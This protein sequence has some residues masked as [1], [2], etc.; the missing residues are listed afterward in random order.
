MP[1]TST[2]FLEAFGR[3]LTGGGP[4]KEEDLYSVFRARSELMGWDVLPQP[5]PAHQ[6]G[7]WSM[8]E[9][10]LGAGSDAPRIG[11]AQVGLDAGV[12]LVMAMP[13][14][15]DNLDNSLRYFGA[16]ELSGYQVTATHLEPHQADHTGWLVS[17]LNWFGPPSRSAGIM[18][19]GVGD[20]GPDLLA[21]LRWQNTGLF[22][23]DATE[24]LTGWGAPPEMMGL[25]IAN[26][27]VGLEAKLSG[28]PTAPGWVMAAT[29]NAVCALA[30]NVTDLRISL[31]F[32]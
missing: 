8:H 15:T 31:E 5:S 20:I 18:V 2:V 9:A 26:I 11:F 28:I 12:P 24:T 32:R 30:P 13:A 4:T 6:R 16:V 19:Y 10:E 21:R 23:F 14:L 7:L 17:A 1:M 27:S 25:E 29:I 3:F 22:Q